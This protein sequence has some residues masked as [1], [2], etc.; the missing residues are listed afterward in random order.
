[1]VDALDRHHVIRGSIPEQ[2]RL[3][4]HIVQQQEDVLAAPR[5]HAADAD[6]RPQPLA[7]LIE[8][9]D[10]GNPAQ[11][12]IRI[13]GARALNFLAGDDIDRA[14]NLLD[15]FLIRQIP[16]LHIQHDDFRHLHGPGSSRSRLVGPSRRCRRRSAV[17]RQH[18]R[19][20]RASGPFQGHRI[21]RRE[22]ERQAGSRQ[23]LRQRLFRRIGPDQFARGPAGRHVVGKTHLEPRCQRKIAQRRVEG[24]SRN[25]I[26]P[27]GLR[28][29]RS[30]GLGEGGRRQKT[31]HHDRDAPAPPP[32][33]P[34]SLRRSTSTRP[35][36]HASLQGVMFTG[37]QDADVRIHEVLS[38]HERMRRENSPLDRGR[39]CARTETT[40]RVSE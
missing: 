27:C 12:F 10:A 38:V 11:H 9:V 26:V 25:P 2:G 35:S 31:E 40:V 19:N 17:R 3:N 21:G 5:I 1:M 4:R 13:L 24:L 14:R 34:S 6:V 15:R 30:I 33:A 32:L 36:L 29:C 22:A 20:R 39:V 8:H 37:H 23:Q 28:L 18:N 16:L 7:I